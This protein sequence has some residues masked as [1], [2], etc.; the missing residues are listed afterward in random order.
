M[1]PEL[2]ARN[3]TGSRFELPL[4]PLV[5][6]EHR[7]RARAERAVVQEDDVWVEQELAAHIHAD[8]VSDP[9]RG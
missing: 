2:R 8:T 7:P 4:P 3:S 1:T 5:G 6:I 9:V